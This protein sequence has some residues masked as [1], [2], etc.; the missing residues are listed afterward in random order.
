MHNQC[1]SANPTGY[2]IEVISDLSSNRSFGGLSKYWCKN[3]VNVQFTGIIS[4]RNF[5]SCQQCRKSDDAHG[6]S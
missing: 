5:S 6:N 3:H 1:L 4:C 2:M